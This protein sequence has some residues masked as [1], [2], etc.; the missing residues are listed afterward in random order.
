[1]SP[2]GA[3]WLRPSCSHVELTAAGILYSTIGIHPCS[4]GIF[5]GSGTNLNVSDEET[6]V[7]PSASE[8]IIHDLRKL[9]DEARSPDPSSAAG[10][11][12]GLVAFGEF[13]LDY[14]RLHF[15]SRRLQ[16][17]SFA[18]QL[19]LA[20]SLTPQLPL[21][22]HSRAAHSDFVRLLKDAFGER[23]ERLEKGGVVHS[24]TGTA[25]EMRELMDLGLHIGIN[26]CSFKTKEN[27]EVVGEVRLDRLMLETDGPWCEIRPSH[28]GWRYVVSDPSKPPAADGAPDATQSTPS[29]SGT[30]AGASA[31]GGGRRSKKQQQA[32]KDETPEER[33]KVV[34]KEKWVEGA[35]VKGRNEPC[36]IEKVGKVVAGIKGVEVKEV[37]EAA[38]KNTVTVFGLQD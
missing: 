4:S 24:F 16:L 26:G 2:S 5:A 13:G 34:K 18:A 6:P 31:A 11:A 1:M 20:A 14:D 21:F 29:G 19:A 25:A 38:W 15:C 8:Q 12:G 36:M 3:G 35:L 33:W 30:G 23:L 32:K 7:D 22:L 28:E 37:C 27:C 10:G 9:V 17:H